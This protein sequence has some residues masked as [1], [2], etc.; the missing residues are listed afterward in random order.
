M[1][2]VT[3]CLW[4]HSGGP[5]VGCAVA[6]D[7]WT[8]FPGS[9]GLAGSIWRPRA[10]SCSEFDPQGQ[11]PFGKGPAWPVGWRYGL[12]TI[13][14][15]IGP[16]GSIPASA[17]KENPSF[18]LIYILILPITR[19][20]YL[21][22]LDKLSEFLWGRNSKRVALRNGLISAPGSLEEFTAG[23]WNIRKAP[24]L[25]KLTGTENFCFL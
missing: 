11:T 3:E 16:A 5:G 17:P 8:D 15:A 13:D 23:G 9:R 4:P 12:P 7:S 19:I 1:I 2:C 22:M 25:Q 6:A 18:L 10:S 14:T 24:V 21:L 20:C